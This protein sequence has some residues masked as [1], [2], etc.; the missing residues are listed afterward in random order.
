MTLAKVINF[1]RIQQISIQVKKKYHLLLLLG[2]KSGIHYQMISKTISDWRVNNTVCAKKWDW[3]N[4]EYIVLLLV[5]C[6]EIQHVISWWPIKRIH[7]LPPHLSYVSTLPDITQIL[8]RNI[9]ELKHWHL[10]KNS[11]GH[12]RQSHWPVANTAACM[13]KGKGTSLQTHTVI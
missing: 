6:N 11:S 2:L 4:I 7:Y 12:H 8:K 5:Y 1:I 13:C 9:D 3:R 10:K